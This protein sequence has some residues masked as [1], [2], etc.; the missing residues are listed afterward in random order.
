MV[1]MK[2]LAKRQSW[3]ERHKSRDKKVPTA[4]VTFEL[5][6]L[7][8]LLAGMTATTWPVPSRERPLPLSPCRNRPHC[9]LLRLP[10]RGLRA[11]HCEAP[12]PTEHRDDAAHREDDRGGNAAPWLRAG[13]TGG[14]GAG[15]QGAQLCPGDLTRPCSGS[16]ARWTARVD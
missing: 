15:L 3:P 1:E 4:R 2:R 9:G 8:L 13:L 16:A 11:S 7:V 12:A 10:V 5:S 14:P 6:R